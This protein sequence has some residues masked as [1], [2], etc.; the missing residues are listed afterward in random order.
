VLDQFERGLLFYYV[1]NADQ[2]SHMMWRARDPGHPAYDPHHDP[3]FAQVVEERYVALDAMVGRTLKRLRP[4]DLLIVMS[5]HGFTSWRRSFNLNGWLRDHGYLVLNSNEPSDGSVPFEHV[6]WSRTRAY[7]LGLNGLYLNLQGREANGV[8]PAGERAA[9]MSELVAALGAA[10]DPET[11]EPLVSRVYRREEAYSRGFEDVAPDL[12][13][14][15]AKGV[16]SSDESSLGGVPGP[17]VTTNTTPW[18]G[19]HC[20]DPVTVP[21]VLFTS[22]PLVQPASSL[23]DLAGSVLREFG[24][25]GFPFTEER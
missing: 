22:R 5:D 8:V 7:G 14:G 17:V 10:R 23:K 20:M 15:Y 6:D 4:S 3:E 16:R 13:V 2:V 18:N 11:G 12:V 19:D 25:E 1:G 21:G 24:I 9:L